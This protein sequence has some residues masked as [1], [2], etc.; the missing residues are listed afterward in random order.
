MS[1]W[2]CGSCSG[3]AKNMV[4]RFSRNPPAQNSGP[5]ARVSASIGGEP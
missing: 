2:N 5:A 4:S 3:G 1:F